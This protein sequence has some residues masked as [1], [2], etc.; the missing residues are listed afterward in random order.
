MA[1]L[2]WAGR[3][4]FQK[5]ASRGP[6]SPGNPSLHGITALGMPDVCSDKLVP[7]SATSS[8]L[9]AI[10]GTKKQ[11][12]ISTCD[13]EC[14]MQSGPTIPPVAPTQPMARDCTNSRRLALGWRI[15]R[16]AAMGRLGSHRAWDCLVEKAAP[17]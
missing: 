12:L 17:A 1:R 9:R 14:R 13:A 15:E 11:G 2:G 6:W 7:L 16:G 5:K 8:Q 10:R 4:A 3:H